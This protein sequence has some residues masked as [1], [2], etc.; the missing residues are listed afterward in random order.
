M[1]FCLKLLQTKEIVK[2]L[3]EQEVTITLDN[4][5]IIKSVLSLLISE[6]RLQDEFFRCD[7]I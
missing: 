4:A 5:C 2:F 3:L 7:P 6:P 1:A